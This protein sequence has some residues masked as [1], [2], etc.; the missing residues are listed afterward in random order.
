MG[1]ARSVDIQGGSGRLASS[2]DPPIPIAQTL[3]GAREWDPQNLGENLTAYRRR[4]TVFIS[5]GPTGS[6][7]HSV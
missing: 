1:C 6:L 2:S 3:Q 5:F 7:P 4:D